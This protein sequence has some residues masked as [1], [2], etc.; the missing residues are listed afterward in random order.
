MPSLIQE[1]N[2]AL[3]L[4]GSLMPHRPSSSPALMEEREAALP[5]AFQVPD[6]LPLLRSV[7]PFFAQTA[8]L[9]ESKEEIEPPSA[10]PRI[11]ISPQQ[12][13]QTPIQHSVSDFFQ[14]A[15][16][17]NQASPAKE[18]AK[19][20]AQAPVQ[21]SQR[22]ESNLSSDSG[23]CLSVQGFFQQTAWNGTSSSPSPPKTEIGTGSEEEST[24]DVAHFFEDIRW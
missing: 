4:W 6:S 5:A 17:S 24:T 8:W 3:A 16:W 21:E 14:N 23:V 9:G 15:N 22:Q 2:E 7:G 11:Q 20:Q 1:L 18:Q 12:Q 10:E 19:E 13:I